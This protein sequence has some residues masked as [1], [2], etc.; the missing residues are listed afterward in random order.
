MS[1]YDT[2]IKLISVLDDFGELA[3]L[4]D[5]YC[6]EYNSSM[7]LEAECR[8]LNLVHEGHKVQCFS[9]SGA[10]LNHFILQNQNSV[11]TLLCIIVIHIIL[12]KN[13]CEKTQHDALLSSN[14]NLL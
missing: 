12:E 10:L 8:R 14:N 5:F 1:Q 6:L 4:P 7:M 11:R 3:E 9:S 13:I 2:Q